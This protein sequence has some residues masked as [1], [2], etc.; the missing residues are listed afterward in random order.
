MGSEGLLEGPEGLSEGPE[1]LSEGSEGLSDGHGDLSEG[2]EGL[3]EGPEGLPEGPEGPESL[4]EGPEEAQGG[5]TYGR[6]YVRNFSPFYR[7]LSPV[8]AAAQKRVISLSTFEKW[9]KSCC[10]HLLFLQ[11]P[12][13][14]LQTISSTSREAKLHIHDLWGSLQSRNIYSLCSLLVNVSGLPWQSLLFLSS[15]NRVLM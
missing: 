14:Q 1:G 15:V 2:S 5:W 3:P 9:L 6:V 12:I 4:P 7:T 10:G 8:G 13:L 11:R